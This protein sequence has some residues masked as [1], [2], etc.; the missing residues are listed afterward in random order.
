M[1]QR[2]TKL[3]LLRE[4]LPK[5]VDD[6]RVELQRVMQLV[7]KTAD[8]DVNLQKEC[9]L[10]HDMNSYCDCIVNGFV[11]HDIELQDD[12]DLCDKYSELVKA[13]KSYG[14]LK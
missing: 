13:Q 9:Y 4:R 2:L 1:A 8:L 7:D 11:K 12:E 10:L 5:L 6:L 14:D 3:N